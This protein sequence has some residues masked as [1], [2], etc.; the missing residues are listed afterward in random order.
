M[1]TL[2]I[3][4]M[5]FLF[6]CVE[7][8]SSFMED[9][10]LWKED[11]INSKN[12][13]MTQ[14]MFNQIADAGYSVY[15]TFAEQ[16]NETLTIKKNWS[17]SVVNANCSRSLGKVTI[18]VYGGLAR[19]AEIT[20]DGF[21]LVLCHELGHAYGGIPYLQPYNKMSA[22]GQ[23][24]YYG[25]KECLKNI[26]SKL[27]PNTFAYDFSNNYIET[28]CAEVYGN[29][30]SYGICLRQLAAG[31]SLGLLLSKLKN[32]PAPDY[33]TPDQTT[34]TE[35]ELSYPSTIQCRLDSYHN[36]SLKMDRPKCWFKN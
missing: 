32:E 27:P 16:N 17:E 20:S 18:N 21:A 11:D 28:K 30:E 15:K 14:E 24:D 36:G 8:N 6:S 34:V 26:M 1:R 29:G 7:K 2:L 25:V 5:F 4:A 23:S 33:E 22:E 12:A 13:N 35:T 31:N 10:D 3:F 19:R 9:N